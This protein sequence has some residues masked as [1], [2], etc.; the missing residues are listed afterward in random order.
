MFKKKI[1]KILSFVSV[2]LALAIF[3]SLSASPV[4]VVETDAATSASSINSDINSVKDKLAELESKQNTLSNKLAAA[5]KEKKESLQTKQLLEEQIASMETEMEVLT[6]YIASLSENE[7]VLEARIEELQ[8]EYDDAYE[9]YCQRVRL[10][11]ERGNISYLEILL[12]AESFS[13]MLTR[14]DYV[15]AVTRYDSS[16]V[17]KMSA[18]LEETKQSKETLEKAIEENK[19]ATEKLKEKQSTYKTTISTLESTIASLD[20]NIDTYGEELAEFNRLER[21]FQSQL[22]ALMDKQL[23]YM[24]GDYFIWPVPASSTMS[25]YFGW[26]TYRINGKV[27]TDYHDALDIAAPSGTPIVAAASGTV[28]FAGWVTTGGGYKTVIDHGGMI[29][30]QY[31][32]QSKILVRTGQKVNQG[33]KIGLVGKTGSA[34]GNHLHFKITKNGTAVNPIYYI[35]YRNDFSVLKKI[36]G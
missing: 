12:G 27:V 2:F 32:H 23:A 6:D 24:G 30:T 34:T 31:C 1:T 13:D 17:E 5:K 18:S 29:S 21:E 8:S 33:D 19:T 4:G 11:Y 3:V 22:D 26:R 16:L 36:T 10:N 28:I 25:S 7:K 9:K 35:N 20:D 15:M 14:L